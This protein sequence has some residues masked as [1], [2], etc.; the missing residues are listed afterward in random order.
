MTELTQAEIIALI[1][2]DIKLHKYELKCSRKNTHVVSRNYC[3][4]CIN[5]LEVL[6]QKILAGNK[7]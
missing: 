3:E 7:G 5:S 4:G 6:K 2:E 1:D